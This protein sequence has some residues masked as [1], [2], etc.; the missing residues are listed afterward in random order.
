MTRKLIT[1]MLLFL[2][3]TT[4]A[5]GETH[6]RCGV[7][8]RPGEFRDDQQPTALTGTRSD[9]LWFGGDDGNGLAV[10]NEYWDFE[11]GT[12]Q[13]CT[14][15]DETENPGDY[16]EW[17]TAATF[18]AHGDPVV[19]L[20]EIG[21]APTVGQI[22]CGI[23]E[24]EANA[25]DFVAGIGYQNMQCQRTFSPAFAVG[26]EEAPSIEFDFFSHSEPGYDYTH[27]YVLGF[28]G[29]GELLVEE[30]L[31]YYDGATGDETQPWITPV[32][33]EGITVP[34]GLLDGATTFQFEFRMTSDGGWSDEDG[35]WDS[36]G[37]PFAF[38]NAE[39][40]YTG[41]TESYD[42]DTG[43]DGWAFERCAGVGA[44]LHLVD[45]IDYSEWLD[46]LG[47]SC[48]CT[49]TGWTAGFTG[50]VDPLNIPALLPG[51]KEMFQTGILPRGSHQP[52]EWNAAVVEWDAYVNFPQSTG[53]HYRPGYRHYPFS[54]SVNPIPHWSPRQ[55]QNVWYYTSSPGCGWN[56]TNL[57]T[58][59]GQAGQPLATEWDSL[60]FSYEIYCSCDAFGTP[61]TVCTEEGWTKGAP[62]IDNIRIG[63]MH[64]ADAPPITWMA[65]GLIADG[66]GQNFPSYL[67]PSDRC[68]FNASYNLSMGNTDENDWLADTTTVTGPIVT[69]EDARWLAEFCF[70]IARKG[71]RQDLIPEYNAWKARMAVHGDPEVEFIAVLLDSCMTGANAWKHKFCTYI[72]E[73]D[74][75]FNAGYAHQTDEQEVLLDG[76]LVPGTRVEY[77]WRSYWYNGGA[78]PEDYYY[79]AEPNAPREFECLPTMTLVPG[80]EFSVQWPAVLYIDAFNRGTEQYFGPALDNLGIGYD[81]YDYQDASS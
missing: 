60:R 80:E 54:T 34:A 43:P 12:L 44:Y 51:Q 42:F 14:S 56:R 36:P 1:P 30:E 76:M 10:A 35:L 21:G 65:G 78:L 55:G 48:R 79:L 46:M 9:T 70:R 22:W 69:T 47:L 40:T 61:S 5:L 3:L 38:D 74:P 11:D 63:L 29:V 13:G 73:S 18:A 27:V 16:F 52:P 31:L 37:G 57:S 28:D 23:H 41:G 2:G 67:E 15:I 50:T 68:N 53:G 8:Y 6:Q 66:F 25:R 17:V 77:Y 7:S 49:L 62:L 19:P 20:I 24:D 39:I 32:L 72:H 26:M 64:A 4:I 71:A 45:E 81:K 58:L 59:N 33:D 75:A